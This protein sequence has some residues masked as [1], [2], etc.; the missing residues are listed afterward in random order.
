LHDW[1]Q[2]TCEQAVKDVVAF[3]TRHSITDSYTT[4]VQDD[5][6]YVAMTTNTHYFL[7]MTRYL[8][9]ASYPNSP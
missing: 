6:I 7:T 5:E 3:F 9:D 8:S 2:P 1:G 4:D